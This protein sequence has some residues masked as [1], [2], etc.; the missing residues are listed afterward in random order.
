MVDN[1]FNNIPQGLP[2]E[3]F[4][5]LIK[6][7]KLHIERIV[8]CGQTTPDAQWYDQSQNEWVMVLQGAAKIKMAD[9]TIIDLTKGDYLNIPAYTK[10]RVEWT[11]PETETIWLAIH[12]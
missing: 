11:Q 12:Y 3:L 6:N 7:Q 5:T 10:H 2:E 4:E 1:I 8:S 9:G